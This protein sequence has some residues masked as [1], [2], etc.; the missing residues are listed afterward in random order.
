MKGWLGKALLKNPLTESE[1]NF[2]C[3]H[4]V[5]LFVNGKGPVLQLPQ[6]GDGRQIVTFF[7]FK[8]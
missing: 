6:C 1:I 2:T 8:V 3:G 7:D 5:D 4:L